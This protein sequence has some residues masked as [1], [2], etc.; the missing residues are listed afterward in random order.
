MA[1]P[2]KDSCDAIKRNMEGNR[3]RYEE[4]L[5]DAR[6]SGQ[7]AAK[8]IATN[9]DLVKQVQREI[10]ILGVNTLIRNRG[11]RLLTGI[12]FLEEL[13]VLNT[14]QEKSSQIRALMSRLKAAHQDAITASAEV[15]KFLQKAEKEKY[16]LEQNK[17]LL[18]ECKDV[19]DGTT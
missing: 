3:E 9:N 19:S 15:E 2:T 11:I 13:D 12:S 14:P 16:S 5:A 18:I 10:G 7:K 8:Y 4:N 1:V 6:R 17:K